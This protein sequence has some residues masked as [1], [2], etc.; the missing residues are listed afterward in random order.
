MVGKWSENGDVV[1]S[2]CGHDGGQGQSQMK[3]LGECKIY[4]QSASQEEACRCQK[5]AVTIETNDKNTVG[6]SYCD[7]IG[8]GDW[9]GTI[10]DSEVV[11]IIPV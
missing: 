2:D 5:I 9:Y 10:A 11:T 1:D 3:D 6:R 7:N 4:G 8:D